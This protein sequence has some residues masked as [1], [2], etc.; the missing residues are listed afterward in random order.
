MAEPIS[1][2]TSEL[3]AP[4]F[5]HHI[6]ILSPSKRNSGPIKQKEHVSFHNHHSPP[7]HTPTHNTD[8]RI[9]SHV[10]YSF[11]FVEM[12]HLNVAPVMAGGI[13]EVEGEA[14]PKVRARHP[15]EDSVLKALGEVR[16]AGVPR[17]IPLLRTQTGTGQ[18]D[19]PKSL[20]KGPMKSSKLAAMGFKNNEA[21]P[22]RKG[23]LERL[24]ARKTPNKE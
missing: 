15:H 17:D 10:T 7:Q 23:K 4:A 24:V 16:V 22:G 20:D 12:C 5:I 19:V 3:R 14:G 11:G 21:L 13:E 2:P 8:I 1:E 18:Q 6:I 9:N